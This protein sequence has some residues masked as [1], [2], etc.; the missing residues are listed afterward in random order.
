MPICSSTFNHGDSTGCGDDKCQQRPSAFHN[1]QSANVHPTPP[2]P[3]SV[4]CKR[5]SAEIN[6]L[7]LV[8]SIESEN[9][10]EEMDVGEFSSLEHELA[11]ATGR[12][13]LD[14]YHNG[15]GNRRKLGSTGSSSPDRNDAWNYWGM[16]RPSLLDYFLFGGRDEEVGEEA[17]ETQV[18]YQKT[19]TNSSSA[20]AARRLSRRETAEDDE[21]P[22]LRKDRQSEKEKDGC[23]AT[24]M[25][26]LPVKKLKLPVKIPYEDESTTTTLVEEAEPLRSGQCDDDVKST[27]K[28]AIKSD[29]HDFCDNKILVNDIV[30]GVVLCGESEATSGSSE[31]QVDCA[32]K[33]G[34]SSNKKSSKRKTGL[35]SA[36]F[37]QF[38]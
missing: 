16:R 4:V 8:N 7:N 34:K 25:N 24:R 23:D 2:Q 30:D 31:D 26:Q 36:K 10:P 15:N 3:T 37:Y 19:Q 20:A 28:N 33:S 17:C 32:G 12:D 35:V 38:F 22:C 18:D 5:C 9:D 21:D 29:S 11:R 1:Y 13:R 6:L 27:R 14:G